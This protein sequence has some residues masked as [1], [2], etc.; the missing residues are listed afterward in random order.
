MSK[1]FKTCCMPQ[2]LYLHFFLSDQIEW[3]HN[4][5]RNSSLQNRFHLII[6]VIKLPKLLKIKHKG[7]LKDQPLELM[8]CPPNWFS[9]GIHFKW[10]GFSHLF[11]LPWNKMPSQATTMAV[12]CQQ[13]LPT[14]KAK[15][16]VNEK[17]YSMLC[18][19]HRLF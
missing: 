17:Y 12:I 15:G 18:K 14:I 11:C 8:F 13:L 10:N 16:S 1:S 5:W 19:I 2:S 6:Q 9:P 3:Y 4:C 7:A